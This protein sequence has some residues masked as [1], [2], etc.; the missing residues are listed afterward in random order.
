MA[1]LKAHGG[2]CDCEVLMNA[3]AFI[4]ERQKPRRDQDLP[5]LETYPVIRNGRETYVV[6][7][8]LTNKERKQI[9]DCLRDSEGHRLHD[10][11]VPAFLRP[12]R[13]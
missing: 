3:M 2:F 9:R 4:A 11:A 5:F 1:L 10:A 13:C 6:R 12:Q 7:E 8:D